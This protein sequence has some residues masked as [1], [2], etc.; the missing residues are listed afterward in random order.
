M[1][2]SLESDCSPGIDTSW[3]HEQQQPVFWSLLLVVTR[4]F[5]TA[6]SLVTYSDATSCIPSAELFLTALSS[7]FLPFLTDVLFLRSLFF[8]SH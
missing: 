8:P 7:Y 2:F 5:F 4:A 6:N 3:R 1:L